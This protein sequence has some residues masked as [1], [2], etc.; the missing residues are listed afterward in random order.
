MGFWKNKDERMAV[1]SGR[2]KR[3]PEY[4]HYLGQSIA[5]GY[6]THFWGTWVT[7]NG[8]MITIDADAYSES[9]YKRTSFYL[10]RVQR[11]LNG[12]NVWHPITNPSHY[13]IGEAKKKG[14]EWNVK[15]GGWE[16]INGDKKSEVKEALSPT[17]DM[18]TYIIGHAEENKNEQS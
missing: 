18:I 4:Y 10:N 7:T 2:D 9:A 1:I 16:E 12:D 14:F 8:R 3:V 5:D 6:V 17:D 13:L 11:W 15:I